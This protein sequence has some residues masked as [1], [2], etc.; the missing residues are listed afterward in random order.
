MPAIT[1]GLGNDDVGGGGAAVGAGAG[2]GDGGGAVAVGETGAGVGETGV[3]YMCA[4]M[5]VGTVTRMFM[6]LPCIRL[7][8]SPKNHSSRPRK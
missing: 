5:G 2:A 7:R 4:D 3:I 1:H 8:S 6:S